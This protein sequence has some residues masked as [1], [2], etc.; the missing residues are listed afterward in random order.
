MIYVNENLEKKEKKRIFI[1]LIISFV[2]VSLLVAFILFYNRVFIIE[3]NNSD[4]IFNYPS[5]FKVRK[6]E[7]IISVTSKDSI[8]Q[9]NIS[10]KKNSSNYLSSQYNNISNDIFN[11]TVNSNYSVLSSDCSDHICSAVYESD[12]EKLKIVVEFRENVLVTYNYCVSKEKFDY[13]S[14]D[15]DTILNS[16][17]IELE[18]E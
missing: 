1:Y 13:Y 14:D 18:E 17:T 16:F 5:N 15:F 3:Y 7:D 9:I 6:K 12:K 4:V 11:K 10:I 8:A 2:I